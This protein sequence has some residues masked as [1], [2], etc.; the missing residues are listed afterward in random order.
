MLEIICG[1]RIFHEI[2]VRRA[3]QQMLT[4]ST[5]VLCPDLLA[6][7]ALYGQALFGFPA[8]IQA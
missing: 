1:D 2:E 8:N 7:D 5:G 4:L 3:L 6:V